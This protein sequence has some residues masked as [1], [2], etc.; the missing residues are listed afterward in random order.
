MNLG[1]SEIPPLSYPQKNPCSSMVYIKR[2]VVFEMCVS[3]D[4]QN[5]VYLKLN[6]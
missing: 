4:H 2:K 6:L 1:K 5:L 3:P